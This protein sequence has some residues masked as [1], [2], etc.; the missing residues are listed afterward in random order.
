[1]NFISVILVQIPKIVEQDEKYQYG[2]AW[3]IIPKLSVYFI[4]YN[5]NVLLDTSFFY[6]CTILDDFMIKKS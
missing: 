6:I 3:T 4:V 1:M 2:A 5:K